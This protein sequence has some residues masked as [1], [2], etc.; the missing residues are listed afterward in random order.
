MAHSNP[1]KTWF[2]RELIK[3]GKQLYLH[4]MTTRTN[5][6]NVTKRKGEQKNVGKEL[7]EVNLSAFCSQSAIK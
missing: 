3:I 5:V 1:K 6:K 7:S 2:S 4:S